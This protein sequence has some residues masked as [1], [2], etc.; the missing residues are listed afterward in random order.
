MMEFP[1]V[2]MY[3]VALQLKLLGVPA[4]STSATGS[5]EFLGKHPEFS[6][7]DLKNPFDP[8]GVDLEYTTLVT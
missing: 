8:V 4:E 2:S 5:W 1:I 7:L 3:R 6:C